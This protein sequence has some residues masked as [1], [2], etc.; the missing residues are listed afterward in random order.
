MKFINNHVN[1]ILPGEKE[2]NYYFSVK[3]A[4]F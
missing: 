2:A 3:T 4:K 1:V